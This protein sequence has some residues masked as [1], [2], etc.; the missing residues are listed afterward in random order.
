MQ[1]DL[2]RTA[3]FAT[4]LG[5]NPGGQTLVIRIASKT[6]DSLSPREREVISQ[7]ASATYSDTVT[8]SRLHQRAIA[9]ALSRHHGVVF[10][11]PPAD[12]LAA[13]SDITDTVLAHAAGR[14]PH[15]QR[16]DA[17]MRSFRSTLRPPEWP[18]LG[19]AV[20]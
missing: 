19:A 17:D 20:S 13:A 6:W 14:S 11:P 3:R 18:T 9:E 8:L 5:L 16:L 15:C 7:A 2:H 12:I 1:M 10:S 4:T